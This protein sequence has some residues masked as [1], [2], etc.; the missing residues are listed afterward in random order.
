MMA[1][2]NY[3]ELTAFDVPAAKHFYEAAF[4]WTTAACPNRSTITPG[5]PSASA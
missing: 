2:L 1:R 4:G 3:V 5:S